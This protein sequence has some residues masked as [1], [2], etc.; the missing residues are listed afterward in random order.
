MYGD[1][2]NNMDETKSIKQGGQNKMKSVD[3]TT[4][5][6]EDGRVQKDKK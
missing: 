3:N 2:Q 4:S 1:G 5:T 6:K